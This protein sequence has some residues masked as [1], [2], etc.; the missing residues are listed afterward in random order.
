[1]SGLGQGTG[2]GGGLDP[3]KFTLDGSQA[4]QFTMPGGQMPNYQGTQMMPATLG[5]VQGVQDAQDWT[6]AIA[7][8]G[9]GLQSLLQG[10]GAGASGLQMPQTGENVAQAP[11]GARSGGSA[12]SANFTPSQLSMLSQASGAM[13]GGQSMQNLLQLLQMGNKGFNIR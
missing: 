13:S 8:S 3:S 11:A 9:N 10:L 4:S 5:G 6:K 2:E 7:D 12:Q 1:M